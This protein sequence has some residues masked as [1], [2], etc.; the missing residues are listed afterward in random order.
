MSEFD[1]LTCDSD[2]RIALARARSVRALPTIFEILLRTHGLLPSC[3]ER[4]LRPQLRI[5]VL[6]RPYDLGGKHGG[7]GWGSQ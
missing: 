4:G 5:L 2:A 1:S 7:S 6:L 3:T